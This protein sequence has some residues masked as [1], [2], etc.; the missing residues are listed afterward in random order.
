MKDKGHTERCQWNIVTFSSRLS[1]YSSSISSVNLILKW[2]KFIMKSILSNFMIILCFG[3]K[4]S[5]HIASP[6]GERSIQILKVPKQ[7]W[8]NTHVKIMYEKSFSS[9]NINANFLI[10][11]WIYFYSS[12]YFIFIYEFS[13]CKMLTAR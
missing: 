8:K 13:H 5:D 11:V 12:S 6:Y 3:Y 9:K 4:T 7:Q 1:T 2:T 10:L